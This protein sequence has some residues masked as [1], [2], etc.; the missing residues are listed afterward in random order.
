M[1]SNR[2][3]VIII[4]LLLT[5]SLT[6]YILIVVIPARLARQSYE[7][8]KEIGRDIKDLFQFTPEVTVNNVVV[9]EQQTPVLELATLSQTFRHEYVWS[10][11][12][13]SSTKKIKITGTMEAKAGFDLNRKFIINITEDKARVTI[14]QAKLLSLEPKGDIAFSDENGI[15]NWVKPEDRSKAIN[16][17]TLNAKA[18][19]AKADFVQAAQKHLEAKLTEILKLHGKEV[20]IVYD[21]IPAL[22]ENQQIIQK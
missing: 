19:A 12:W 4:V 1:F 8:A 18:Y 14:P 5:V 7:G 16:A 11:T 15:W 3:L 17:F 6:G 9:L 21:E 13:L 2:K 20:E 22:P 10:N